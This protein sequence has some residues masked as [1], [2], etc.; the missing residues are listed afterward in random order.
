MEKVTNSKLNKICKYLKKNKSDYIFISAPENVA[1]ILNIRGGDVPN[2]PLPNSRLIITKT[3]KIFENTK[4]D[5]LKNEYAENLKAEKD[6]DGNRIFSDED[7][8][9][10]L[11]P[12]E[13]YSVTDAQGW[14]TLDRWRFLNEKLGRFDAQDKDLVAAF[15]RLKEGKGTAEDIKLIVTMP[16]KGMHFELRQEGNLQVPTYIKYSQAVLIP[17]FTKGRE[18]NSLL[19]A[20]TDPK[21]NIDEVIVDSGVKTGALSPSNITGA[22]AGSILSSGE[23]EFNAMNLRNEYWKLQQDLTPHEDGGAQLEGS[24]VKKNML[25]NIFQD[26]LYGDISGHELIRQMHSVD[27]QL[28]DIGRQELEKDFGVKVSNGNYTITNWEK[29]EKRLVEEFT[30]G[31]NANIATKKLLA[32]LEL[33]ASKTGFAVPIDENAFQNKI[34]S[35]IGTFITKKTVKLKMP[36]GTYVQMSPY[37]TQRTTRY[38]DLSEAERNE[39]DKRVNKNALNPA[40]LSK[41]K[42]KRVQILLPSWFADLVPGNESMSAAEIGNYIADNRLLNGIAYRIP[43]QGMSSIDAFEVVGF[44]PKS[45]SDTVI[46]YDELT[47]KTGSDFDIDKMFIM[48]PEYGISKKTGKPY[49]I[50]PSNYLNKDG[51]FKEKDSQGNRITKHKRKQVLRN[52]KLELY[53]SVIEHPKAFSQ[54]ITPLDSITHKYNA[55]KK[56]YLQAKSDIQLERIEDFN[57][58]EELLKNIEEKKSIGNIKKFISEA[59]KVLSETKDLEFF[60]PD[61]QFQIKKTFIGGKY[62]VAQT[63]RHLVDHS[64]SQWNNQIGGKPY[65]LNANIGLGNIFVDGEVVSSS[66]AGITGTVGNLISNTLSGRLN[67]YVDIAKD[68][69]IFYLNNNSVTANVVFML[70]RLGV[71]PTWTDFFTSQPIIEKFVDEKR[72]FDSDG[73]ANIVDNEGVVLKPFEATAYSLGFSKDEYKKAKKAFLSNPEISTT[74]KELEDNLDST[75]SKDSEAYRNLQLRILLQYENLT[76]YA[77]ELNRAVTAS[78]ADTEGA[79]GGIYDVIASEQLKAELSQSELVLG[80]EDR[81]NRTMLGTYY[82]NSIEFMKSLFGDSFAVTSPAFKSAINRIEQ[83]TGLNIWG[84]ADTLRG[85]TE[86]LYAIYMGEEMAK[87]SKQNGTPFYEPTTVR[88]LFYGKDSLTKRLKEFQKEGSPIADN[89][90]VKYLVPKTGLTNVDADFITSTRAAEKTSAD[91]NELIDAFEELLID[92]DPEIVSFAE[93]L[94]VYS[95]LTT[96]NTSTI[97]GFSELVPLDF[98]NKLFNRVKDAVGLASK[99]ALDFEEH[100]RDRDILTLVRNNMD[101]SDNFGRGLVQEVHPDNIKTVSKSG[102]VLGVVGNANRK[103]PVYGFYTSDPKLRLEDGEYK[104]FAK[105]TNDEG[106]SVL[107]QLAGVHSYENKNGKIF[108]APVYTYAPSL[109]YKRGGQKIVELI[110][111]LASSVPDNIIQ[112]SEGKI[113]DSNTAKLQTM[114]II[115]QSIE[116][117]YDDYQYEKVDKH[118]YDD[119]PINENI[120]IDKNAKITVNEKGLVIKENAIDSQTSIDIVESIQPIIETTSYKQTKG[121]TSFDMGKRWT[122]VT[123]L[124]T[125]ELIRSIVP[126]KQLNGKEITQSMIDTAAK[127]L[128]FGRE[129]PLYAYVGLDKNGNPLPNIP[130]KIIETLKKQGID[131]SEYEAS[132][133]SVYDK[134]DNGS[135]VIHQDNTEQ[136]SSYPIITISLGRPMK[137]VT[138]QLNNPNEFNLTDAQQTPYRIALNL[139]STN[140]KSKPKYGEIT[141]SNIIEYAKQAE[142]QSGKPG[143]VEYVKSTLSKVFKD[144]LKTEHILKDGAILIFSGDN[145]NVLHEIVFDKETDAMPMPKGF[146]TLSVN[147]AFSG[148]GQSDRYLNTND[149]RVVLTLRKITPGKKGKSVVNTNKFKTTSAPKQQTSK[150]KIVNEVYE[151][152]DT[153][154]YSINLNYKGKDYSI[155]ID[156]GGE[157]TDASYYNPNT[158]KDV[159]VKPSLFKFTPKDIEN[160]FLEI[161]QPTQQSGEVNLGTETAPKDGNVI[162]DKVK[163]RK[164]Q[165]GAVVAFRTKGK[166]EQNMIDALKDN[167]VGNPFGP[168]AAIKVDGTGEA[169]TRF[170][171]WLEGTGDTNIMQDYRQ[172]ILDKASELQNKDIYYYKD[173]REFSLSL[174]LSLSL[175]IYIYIYIYIYIERYIYIYIYINT[176]SIYRKI[177]ISIYRKSRF[178]Y[179]ENHDFYI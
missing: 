139:V 96:A 165:P 95:F 37:G 177:K 90:F 39:I 57:R 134:R 16:M 61:Y 124:K 47:A 120:N 164:P 80:F 33:N 176:I 53:A 60:S 7:I 172:A 55:T 112:D 102:K 40:K 4:G 30:T 171:N 167:A 42:T 15:D 122:R 76:K 125:P 110:G 161:E 68:P 70:D 104:R 75:K 156:R 29:L 56:R 159:D 46:A 85:I 58:I 114:P 141:P 20:M 99:N 127:T 128:K 91:L 175:S 147:K 48:L 93:D 12:Y 166:T 9:I 51:S 34:N 160:I 88:R 63:A 72:R 146:P 162:I 92:S 73:R 77:N 94:G 69:Y 152:I 79:S 86:R 135:L 45:M 43:N 158:L 84:N 50:N 3:K 13:D 54:V 174:S 129:W 108:T 150:V 38:S 28:S 32:S 163:G 14:I 123:S 52:K 121:A 23:I 8:E 26:E 149:Y 143:I 132:Y 82:E 41:G 113:I 18:L 169:V 178:L 126:G 103:L 64:I 116:D 25:A 1:W 62:G 118:L 142:K 155:V 111:D 140:L 19:E 133:N 89:I 148:L 36:G 21:N 138:Y 144:S 17:Q 145:R 136:D 106:N 5:A 154:I 131:I 71:D 137:F 78:K 98:E 6:K 173:F 97:F 168:Y 179:I 27:S 66:L 119:L 83:E 101:F 100:F 10:I 67:A 130:T 22:T 170:L 153:D 49:Y 24:Q 151:K 81:F 44:L 59:D 11:S 115:T 74:I 65:R 35:V 105:L 2:S 117:Y 31:S 109:G 157:I 107:Y 87:G